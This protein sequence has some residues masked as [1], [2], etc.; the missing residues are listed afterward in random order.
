VLSSRL[1]MYGP[2]EDAL[3]HTVIYLL[4]VFVFVIVIVVIVSYF[5]VDSSNIWYA[6]K[7]QKMMHQ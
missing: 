1:A 6:S 3:H 5:L 2:E 4:L 7:H